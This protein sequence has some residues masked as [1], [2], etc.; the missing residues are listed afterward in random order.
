MNAQMKRQL[1]QMERAIVYVDEMASLF[2]V[3]AL[4]LANGPPPEVL[5]QALAMLQRRHPLLRV[6]IVHDKGQYRFQEPEGVPPIPLQIKDRPD[7]HRWETVVEGEI[8]RKMDPLTAPLMHARYLYSAGPNARSEIILTCHHTI[9]DAASGVVLC[10]ELLA[11]CGALYAGRPVEQP[12]PLPLMPPA[13]ELYP[14]AFQGIGRLCR[15]VSFVLRQMGDEIAYRRR[16]GTARCPQVHAAVHTR[17][18][19]VQL[20]QEATA[21]FIRRTRREGVTLNSGLSA[22][23]Q[24][25][26]NRLLYGSQTLPVRAIAFA[27]LRPHLKPP[28]SPENLGAYFA[29]LQYPLLMGSHREMWELAREIN[30]KIYRLTK[31]GDKF[32]TPLLTKALFQMMGRQDQFRMG[33]AGMSYTSATSLEQTYGPIRLV[34]LH[35]LFPNNNLG[36]EYGIFARLLF[37]RLWLDIFFMEEDMDRTTARAVADEIVHLLGADE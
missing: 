28:V 26:V 37:G 36:P 10:Q 21:R 8:N 7:D 4:R 27:D 22:A 17:F 3:I 18:L 6:Q 19:P 29:M 9:I 12:K 23:E 11:L 33:A 25:A 16:L 34:G 1:G 35:G 20:D 2:I 30:Q 13:E 32:V 5:E 14:P 15:T 24:L 31:R